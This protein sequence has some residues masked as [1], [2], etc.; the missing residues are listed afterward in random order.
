MRVGGGIGG[1]WGCWRPANFE[2]RTKRRV[3]ARE[4][5][6]AA[7]PPTRSRPRR[8]EPPPA[9]SPRRKNHWE[10]DQAWGATAA[11]L[12]DPREYSHDR[13]AECDARTRCVSRNRHRSPPSS[14]SLCRRRPRPSNARP[15]APKKSRETTRRRRQRRRQTQNTPPPS[16]SPATHQRETPKHNILLL[17]RLIG[18]RSLEERKNARKNRE[19][20]R[21]KQQ[22]P[23]PPPL[24]LPSPNTDGHVGRRGGRAGGPGASFIDALRLLHTRG[25]GGWACGRSCRAEPTAPKSSKK[26]NSSR[27]PNLRPGNINNNQSAQP[28]QKTQRKHSRRW[29]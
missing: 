20:R 18:L 12:M 3:C 23:P 21:E 14:L 1:V 28:P 5:G 24:S 11:V 19:R 26:N 9:S 6:G 15:T 25:A 10:V 4:R 27:P 2:R 29:W 13:V 7:A 17:P 16:P 8:P 22:R